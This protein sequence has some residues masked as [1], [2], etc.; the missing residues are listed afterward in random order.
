MS[1]VGVG[2]LYV[3]ARPKGQD[4]VE[5]VKVS[6]HLA[7]LAGGRP[8]TSPHCTIQ[9]IYNADDIDAVRERLDLVTRTAAPFSVHVTGVGSFFS[10]PPA[11]GILLLVEKTEAL[12]RLYRAI[13]DAV[14]GLGCTCYPY[15]LIAWVPHIRIVEGQWPDPA[16]GSGRALST[17]VADLQSEAPGLSFDVDDLFLSRMNE[18]GQWEEVGRFRLTGT[19][20]AHVPLR[21][22]TAHVADL[23]AR[24]RTFVG[25]RA[26][27]VYHTPKNLAMSIAIEA[28]ELME[29]FQW[30]TP[31]ETQA[32][33]ADPARRAAIE[34]E[35]ADILIYCLSFA[36]VTR[37]DLSA[38]VERKMARN[39]QRFPPDAQPS[40]LT[41]LAE[42]ER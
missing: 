17:V 8:V 27:E 31:E 30:L 12:G 33:L 9:A 32:A 40:R 35:L 24:V 15:T 37:T 41:P 14:A 3:L 20:L 19:S 10:A 39:E 18:A 28:A 36:N 2:T 6:E 4:L 16:T 42:P 5:L 25:E 7:R 38:A 26:W 34:D 22:R 29:E 21:D 1:T 23:L 13:R 11:D